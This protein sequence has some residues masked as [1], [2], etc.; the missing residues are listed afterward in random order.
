VTGQRPV[1]LAALSHLALWP[2]LYITGALA[3]FAQV[4][5]ID[6]LVPTR[7]KLTALGLAF[8]TASAVYLLDRAKLKDAWLDPAD[9]EAHPR[10][11]AFVARHSRAIRVTILLLLLAAT[12]L[13]ARLFAFAW[14]LPPLAALGVTLYAGRPRTA[15]ARPKDILIFKNAVVA[16]GITGFAALIALG[17]AAAPAGTLTAARDLVAGHP[18]A[19][20]ASALHLV[21]RVFADA[22]LCDL[23][24]EAADRSHGTAT[25]PNRFGRARAWTIA[26]LIRIFA[27]AALVPLAF[28]PVD[29]RLAWAVVTLISSLAM[30]LA[31]PG[32]VRDW[33]DARFGAEAL[34]ITTLLSLT[35]G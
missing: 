8:L 7:T 25:L 9:A 26:M 19:L 12:A 10:R 22:A 35:H 33:V 24:D 6:N 31:A 21:L 5:G 28:L 30:R 34:L 4:A 16:A 29:A 13:G 18:A 17:A 3:C 23:D 11:Y 2:G 14:L 32:R 20:T 27:G 1:S 15:H